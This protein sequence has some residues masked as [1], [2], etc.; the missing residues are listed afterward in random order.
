METARGRHVSNSI[1]SSGRQQPRGLSNTANEQKKIR[2]SD[3]D[4]Q[5]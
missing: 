4:L 1:R 3:Y 5:L 2:G